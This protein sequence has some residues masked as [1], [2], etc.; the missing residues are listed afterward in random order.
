M[1]GCEAPPPHGVFLST[2]FVQLRSG[3]D[4]EAGFSC[5]TFSHGEKGALAGGANVAEPVLPA[6]SVSL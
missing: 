2:L 4:A 6:H 1:E 5:E 3:E